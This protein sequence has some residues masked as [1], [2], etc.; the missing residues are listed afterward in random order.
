MS[1]RCVLVAALVLAAPA[2]AQQPDT[3]PHKF[4][5]RGVAFAPDGRTLATVTLARGWAPSYGVVKLWDVAAGKELRAFDLK[6]NR[7]ECVA[8][9]P[10]GRL[11]AVGG[12]VERIEGAF[13][14]TAGVARL[15]EA[16]TGKELLTLQGHKEAVKSLTFSPD[17]RLLATASGDG[18]VALWDV[19]TGQ[20]VRA[21]KG[22]A[23][24]VTAVAFSPDG[25]HLATAGADRTARLWDAASGEVART[26]RGHEGAVHHVAFAPDGRTVA[27][28]GEDRRAVLWDVATGKQRFAAEG[29]GPALALAYSPDGRVLAVASGAKGAGQVRLLDAAR[30][31]VLGQV[32]SDKGRCLGVAF[33]P[34]G[35]RLAVA[36]CGDVG[37]PGEVPGGELRL[38]DVRALLANQP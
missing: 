4:G 23:G 22:H 21:L 36:F 38:Y 6:N 14:T 20:E 35:R 9:S 30:G 8:F 34:D 1:T 27:T 33:S 7:L 11:V 13:R 18:A 31:K 24:A 17:G 19:T 12:S 10:D 2:A 25:K 26:L 3:L 37:A 28:A 32:G 5:V 29:A 16:D 15:F